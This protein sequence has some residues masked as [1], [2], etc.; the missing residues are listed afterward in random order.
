[1]KNKQQ[2]EIGIG[3]RIKKSRTKM[4]LSSIRISKELGLSH[5]ICS[6]WE[7]GNANPSTANLAK[8]AKILNVSFEWLALGEVENKAENQQDFS[9]VFNLLNDKQK[10]HLAQFIK[11]MV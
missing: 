6:Q 2:N 8:L 4:R 3:H 1:M 5:S 10:Q 11:S 9:V 7:R